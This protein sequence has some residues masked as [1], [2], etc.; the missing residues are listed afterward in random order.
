MTV[1]RLQALVFLLAVVFTAVA[2]QPPTKQD[3]K[4]PQ[5]SFEPRSGPGVGQKFLEKFVGEWDVVKTI[6]R[7]AGEPFTQKGECKQTMQQGGRFLHS[8]FVFFSDGGKS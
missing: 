7:S 2:D 5:S 3:K 1:A 8:E 6:H 4:D